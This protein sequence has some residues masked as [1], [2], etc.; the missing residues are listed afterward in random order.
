MSGQTQPTLSGRGR[1]AAGPPGQNGRNVL[2]VAAAMPVLVHTW[3][4]SG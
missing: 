2:S 1:C 4:A 3:A